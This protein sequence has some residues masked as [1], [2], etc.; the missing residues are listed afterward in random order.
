MILYLIFLRNKKRILVISGCGFPN[1]NGNFDALKLQMKNL[2]RF[3][4][5]MICSP[6]TPMLNVYEAKPLTDPLL[7][8]FVEGW[9]I[10]N[11]NL[12]LSEEEVAALENPMLPNEVYINIVN[13]Q[14]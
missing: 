2:F 4:L 13:D 7:N 12:C 6:E 3:N 11:Q 1:W 5:T 8:K 14:K 9:R 10:Y